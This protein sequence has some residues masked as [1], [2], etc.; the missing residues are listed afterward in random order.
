MPDMALE[1]CSVIQ[2]MAGRHSSVYRCT[3][4]GCLAAPDKDFA[5]LLQNTAKDAIDEIAKLLGL[6]IINPEYLNQVK[7]VRRICKQKR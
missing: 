7:R 2:I 3:R 4:S 6:A 1:S 5:K